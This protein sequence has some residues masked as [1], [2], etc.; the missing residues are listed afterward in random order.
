MNLMHTHSSSSSSP[1]FFLLLT[2]IFFSRSSATQHESANDEPII[3]SC[4][5]KSPVSAILVFGDS[6]VDSG[7]NNYI[8][9]LFKSDFPPYG[10][11]FE[12][13]VPTGRFCNGRLPTDFIA[14]YVGVKDN[15]PP[16]LDP[17]LG[18]DELMS[19]VTFA[20][21]GSGY[22]PLTPTIDHVIDLPTQLEYFREYKR[23]I[24]EKL[25]EERMQKH[26]E[27]ALYVVSAG[28]NDFVITYFS[29]PL[30]RKTFIVEGYEQF[31]IYHLKNFIQGL[32]EEGAR[33][34]AVAGLPPMG[35]LPEVITAFSGN[36]V[37]DRRCIDR[38]SA[39]GRDYNFLL[40]RELKLMQM[41]LSHL[42]YKIFYIDIFTPL[43]DMVHNHARYGFEEVD[44]GCCGTGYVELGPLCNPKSYVCPNV[45]RYVFFDSIHPT[46]KTY[47]YVFRAVQSVVDM[48]V[49]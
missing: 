32:C 26:V 12:G 21:A 45:S 36:A 16:Y 9:T 20:S 7:N 41:A 11:D 18:I 43:S 8:K 27:E 29:L 49:N 4:D 17:S 47:Y 15:V 31:I 24:E 23:R 40:Q 38:F 33:K 13:H 42:G 10:Q 48:I 35:C 44:T 1:L 5:K 39:V 34:I 14:S 30:R 19:G 22:D 28:T 2:C 3:E 37:A 25:G 6:T 46:E